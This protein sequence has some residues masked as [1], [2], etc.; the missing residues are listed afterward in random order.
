VFV[1]RDLARFRQLDR[2]D[3]G[4]VAR[5]PAGS[6]FQR[7]FKLPDRRVARTP[8][9]VERII[10]QKWLPRLSNLHHR[11]GADLASDDGHAGAGAGQH[12]CGAD[13]MNSHLTC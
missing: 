6:T 2:V 9:R 8:H 13:D 4:R 11:D 12:F 1:R 10:L 5:R 3:R 7:R